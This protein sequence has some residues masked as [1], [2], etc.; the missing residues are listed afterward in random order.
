MREQ[1]KQTADSLS[2]PQIVGT[3]PDGRVIKMSNR[4]YAGSTQTDQIY[5]VENP[6]GGT[7]IS[8]NEQHVQGKTVVKTV[9]V[10]IDGQKFK[11][12]KQ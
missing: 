11:A 5:F 6:D 7:W 9:E 1:K 12:E 3:L 2:S 10:F 4:Y 8:K